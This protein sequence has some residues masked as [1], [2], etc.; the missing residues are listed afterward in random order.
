MTIRTILIQIA[1]A[2]SDVNLES[3][4]FTLKILDASKKTASHI[5]DKEKNIIIATK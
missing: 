4:Q 2:A 3:S 5:S 1:K